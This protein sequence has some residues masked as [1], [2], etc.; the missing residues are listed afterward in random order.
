MSKNVKRK[1]LLKMTETPE[2]YAAMGKGD[3]Q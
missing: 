1:T 3:Y 2:M